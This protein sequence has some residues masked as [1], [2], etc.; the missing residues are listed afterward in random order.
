MMMKQNPCLEHFFK[1]LQDSFHRCQSYKQLEAL[2]ADTNLN[3]YRLPADFP[4][5]TLVDVGGIV[6][7]AALDL[8]PS[9]V[10]KHLFPLLTG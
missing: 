10:P 4:R 9:S 8:K 5:T 3:P 1:Q 2:V 7:S 6:D